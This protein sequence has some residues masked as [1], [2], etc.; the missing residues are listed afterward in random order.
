MNAPLPL[1]AQ[2]DPLA[3]LRFDNS[4]ARLDPAFYTRLAPTDVQREH[5]HTHPAELVQPPKDFAPV[6]K[7]KGD[8]TRKVNREP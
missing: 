7:F 8:Y 1:G 3:A 6:R 4:F 2:A 5:R